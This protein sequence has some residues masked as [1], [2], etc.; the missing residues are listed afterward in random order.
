MRWS[1]EPSFHYAPGTGARN[2]FFHPDPATSQ[3]RTSHRVMWFAFVCVA[4]VVLGLAELAR[5]ARGAISIGSNSLI[6]EASSKRAFLRILGPG[7]AEGLGSALFHIQDAIV[8]SSALESTL[9]F[10]ES[11]NVAYSLSDIFNGE[12]TDITGLPAPSSDIDGRETCLLQAYITPEERRRLIHGYCGEGNEA[13]RSEAAEELEEFRR[14]LAHCTSFL[15]AVEEHHV[16]LYKCAQPWIR[17]RLGPGPSVAEKLYQ[18]ML[19]IP[20]TRPLTIGVHIRWGDTQLTY[21]ERNKTLYGSMPIPHV[22]TILED[23]RYSPLAAQ[24]IELTVFMQG[25][26]YTPQG[27]EVLAPIDA[28]GIPYRLVDTDGNTPP[29][30]DLY[31][32]GRN[33]VILIGGSAFAIMAHALAPPGVSVVSIHRGRDDGL[34]ALSGFGREGI[35]WEDYTLEGLLEVFS[36]GSSTFGE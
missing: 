7:M 35:Y 30:A 32:L 36:N 34:K 1:T 18:P 24:G 20:P 22:V 19:T 11:S 16:D 27:A 3:P 33:D 25:V 14:K 13:A 21:E 4:V 9:L 28:T 17:A 31:E 12:L 15:D 26:S 8:L 23:L 2:W 10:T 29:L 5:R 6:T